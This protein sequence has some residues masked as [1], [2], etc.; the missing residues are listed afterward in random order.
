MLLCA[1][2]DVRQPGPSSDVTDAMTVIYHYEFD[3]IRVNADANEDIT[4]PGML[5]D[6]R[7]CFAHDGYQ[8]VRHGIVEHC[9]EWSMEF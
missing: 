2:F 9:V 1:R 4:G 6:V 5:H 7:Q 8:M 3:P